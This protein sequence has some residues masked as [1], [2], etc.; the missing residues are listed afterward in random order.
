MLVSYMPLANFA[1]AARKRPVV[2]YSCQLSGAAELWFAAILCSPAASAEGTQTRQSARAAE[3]GH[4]AGAARSE[5]ER[6]AK[7]R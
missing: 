4:I 7:L 1:V 5:R 2:P 3:R 6:E